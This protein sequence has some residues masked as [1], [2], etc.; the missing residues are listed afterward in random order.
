VQI[1]TWGAH[2]EKSAE[3]PFTVEPDVWYR[4]RLR[5]DVAGDRGTVKGKVWRKDQPEPAAW[6]LTLE[7]PMLVKQ[8]SPG[9]YGDSPTDIY[10]DNVTVKVNE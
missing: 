2:L 5:V 1:R 4:A 8:G 9:V 7:D 6:T 3:V 10:Y